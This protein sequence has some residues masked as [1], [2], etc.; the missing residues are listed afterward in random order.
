M[1][2]TKSEIHRGYYLDTGR[3]KELYY[4][5]TLD[6][7]VE[8]HEYMLKN[9]SKILVVRL[10]IRTPSKSTFP[11]RKKMPRILETAKRRLESKNKGKNKIDMQHVWTAEQKTAAGKEHVHLS[12]LVNANA[13]QNGYRLMSAFEDAVLRHIPGA[14]K[15]L[16]H[17]S[18][19]NGKTGILIDRKA[20]DFQ[21]KSDDAIKAASYLAKTNTKEHKAKWA[22]ISSASHLP[23]AWR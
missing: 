16:V 19:S 6:Q 4:K 21:Q 1:K 13:I 12:I 18:E 5:K 7:Y 10:D 9:H 3:E 23:S 22:R 14:K 8:R 17:F 20:P 11:L 2:T 15:G